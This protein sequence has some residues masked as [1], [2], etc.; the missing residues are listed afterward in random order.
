MKSL[1]ET[2]C[3]GLLIL[4]TS[5]QLEFFVLY[6]GIQIRAKIDDILEDFWCN[7]EADSPIIVTDRGSKILKDFTDF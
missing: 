1:K 5:V 2:F 6:L 7:L 3:T 4:S